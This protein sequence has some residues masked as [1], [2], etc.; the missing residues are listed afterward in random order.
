MTLPK[1][2]VSREHPG[3]VVT[4]TWL[5]RIDLTDLTAS[6]WPERALNF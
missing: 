1:V 5:G 4:H 6:W 2:L 3:T